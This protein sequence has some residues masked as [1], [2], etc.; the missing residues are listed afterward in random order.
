MLKLAVVGL[1]WIGLDTP[2]HRA[3][4]SDV[5]AGEQSC[6]EAAAQHGLEEL[7]LSRGAGCRLMLTLRKECE[8]RGYGKGFR[9]SCLQSIARDEFLDVGLLGET[10]GASLSVPVDCNTEK[11][12]GLALILDAEAGVETLLEVRDPVGIRRGNESIVDVD[13]KDCPFAILVEGVEARITGALDE[14]LFNEVGVEENIP[15]A[16]GLG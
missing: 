1:G 6:K 2:E 4:N 10:D 5:R 12:A 11:P 3:A 13:G 14:S 16:R 15:V 8:V 9:G 7:L